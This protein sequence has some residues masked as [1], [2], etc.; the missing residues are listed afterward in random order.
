M[1]ITVIAEIVTQGAN[2][3]TATLA[4]DNRYGWGM[5]DSRGKTLIIYMD[6]E[7]HSNEESWVDMTKDIANRVCG[8]AHQYLNEV[9]RIDKN[10]VSNDGARVCVMIKKVN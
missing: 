8:V 10:H 1:D 6:G 5:Y 4:Y 2:I 3:A 9:W 7:K